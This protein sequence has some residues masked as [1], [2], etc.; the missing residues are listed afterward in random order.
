MEERRK[1]MDKK[2]A[3]RAFDLLRGQF[4]NTAAF[5]NELFMDRYLQKQIRIIIDTLQ[6]LHEEY[7]EDLR[8]HAEG[9]QAQAVWQAARCNGAW[10]R[11]IA[12]TLTFIQSDAMNA[13]LELV[14][15]P[16]AGEPFSPADAQVQDD[17]A[18]V[19]TLF[20]YA[21][22]LCANRAWSQAFHVYL[23]PYAFGTILSNTLEERDLGARHLKLISL[24]LLKLEDFC[25]QHPQRK[26]A[27]QLL[28][29]L[30]TRRW[31]L[32]REMIVTGHQNQ[33]NAE[34]PE[35]QALARA[36]FSGSASTKESLESAFAFVKDSIRGTKGNRFS[37]WTRW[38]YLS[39]NPYVKESIPQV[40]PSVSDFMELCRKK[41]NDRSVLDLNPFQPLK[42]SLGKEFPAPAKVEHVR[43]SGY[44]ANRTAA[45]ATALMLFLA[46]RDFTGVENAWA[47][48]SMS[49]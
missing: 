10:Y 45:A 12:D 21:V 38:M 24:S 34:G 48:F 27:S 23:L 43:P 1:E 31:Q 8:A 5:A 32:V 14:P 42:T 30:G 41:F 11:T 13:R 25:Q 9:Q 47:G 44:D 3:K 29:A 7:A 22:Q 28:E 35:M 6:F 49:T 15:K 37:P 36:V 33:W 2:E 39:A 46:P 19:R 20:T 18:L 26:I 17:V 16:L 4:P 40:C